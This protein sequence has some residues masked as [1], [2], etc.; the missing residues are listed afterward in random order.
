MS[1]WSLSVMVQSSAVG[2]RVNGWTLD[3]VPVLTGEV[4]LWTVLVARV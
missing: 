3:G 1:V 2:L 4:G